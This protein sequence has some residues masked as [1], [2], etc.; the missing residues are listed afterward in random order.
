MTRHDKI[1]S[2]YINNVYKGLEAYL[3]YNLS[4]LAASAV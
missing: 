2:H 3:V 1:V 4:R